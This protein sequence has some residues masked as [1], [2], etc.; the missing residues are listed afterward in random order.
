MKRIFT[1]VLLAFGIH[2]G[3]AQGNQE[4]KKTETD[5]LQDYLLFL[6]ADYDKS[7]KPW[8]LIIFLH[9]SGERGD[10]ISL[11]KTHGP[12]KIVEQ[13]KNFPFILIS[14]QCPA[15]RWWNSGE[16]KL[17]IDEVRNRHR[18]DPQRIYLTGLSMGG[19][20]T[21]EMA[22]RYPVIPIMPAH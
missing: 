4:P 12:P 21:W 18:I 13:D 20:G 15:G 5:Y 9:G 16:L 22:T 6:P 17:L 3:Y 10:D 2:T 14:P 8:P 11:V 19:Y 7:L 1:I